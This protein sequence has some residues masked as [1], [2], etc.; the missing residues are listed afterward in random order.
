MNAE[1]KAK[2]DEH[3]RLRKKF[4]EA[5]EALD[6]FRKSR[7]NERPTLWEIVE[8]QFDD[9]QKENARLKDQLSDS[10][11]AYKSLDKQYLQFRMALEMVK[12]EAGKTPTEISG[13]IV[14]IVSAALEFKE[15]K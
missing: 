9:L 13:V 10:N 12:V 11:I 6:A 3:Q 14:R 4:S 15:D 8:D 1:D 5:K 2:F 7:H